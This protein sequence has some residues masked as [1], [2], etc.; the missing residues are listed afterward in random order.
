[1]QY[2]IHQHSSFAE[3][4]SQ[5][6]GLERPPAKD[7]EYAPACPSWTLVECDHVEEQSAVVEA[8]EGLQVVQHCLA[9]GSSVAVRSHPEP[10]QVLSEIPHDRNFLGCWQ[11]ERQSWLQAAVGLVVGQ[12]GVELYLLVGS[13]DRQASRQLAVGLYPLVGS[14]DGQA[15]LSLLE[16]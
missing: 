13:G 9:M 12:L 7:S 8:V 6:S 5:E 11:L 10:A 4:S 1:M 2:P 3:E 14:G 15:G 16:G